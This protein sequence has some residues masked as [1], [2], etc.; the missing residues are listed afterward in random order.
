VNDRS[1][2][3]GAYGGLLLL[4]GFILWAVSFIV[5]DELEGFG[6]EAIRLADR[7]V[8]FVFT[9]AIIAMLLSVT[10]QDK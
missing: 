5:V 10:V 6:F 8:P 4:G 1:F 3:L 2:R 9:T 7:M